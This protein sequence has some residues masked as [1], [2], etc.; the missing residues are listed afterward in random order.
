MIYPLHMRLLGVVVGFAVANTETE[1]EALTAMGYTPPLVPKLAAPD[2]DPAPTTEPL[3]EPEAPTSSGP[4]VESVR[5]QLD[6]AG[7]EYDRRWGLARLI[8]LLPA[9]GA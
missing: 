3:S 9:E 6:A 8:E 7:I 5:A 1:H 2:P 4:T